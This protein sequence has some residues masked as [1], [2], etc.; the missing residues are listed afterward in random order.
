MLRNHPG[1]P[2]GLPRSRDQTGQG[3]LLFEQEAMTLVR[4]TPVLVA[5]RIIRVNDT[6]F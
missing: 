6:R 1:V 5:A 3:A 4:G 2:G